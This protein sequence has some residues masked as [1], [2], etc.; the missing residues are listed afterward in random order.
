MDVNTA[1]SIQHQLN[2]GDQANKK[3]K[4]T[5]FIVVPPTSSFVKLEDGLLKGIGNH[6]TSSAIN[7]TGVNT[8]SANLITA[9]AVKLTNS[10]G[11]VSSQNLSM[12]NLNSLPVFSTT[13]SQSNNTSTVSTFSNGQIAI[14]TSKPGDKSGLPQTNYLMLNGLTAGNM[15][16]GQFI[17]NSANGQGRS[18][19]MN[20]ICINKLSSAQNGTALTANLGP[21]NS[22]TNGQ[23]SSSVSLAGAISQ[24]A[25]DAINGAANNKVSVQY[26]SVSYNNSGN[27]SITNANPSS[28]AS[29]AA[30][31]G[32]GTF[33]INSAD[34]Q[35]QILNSLKS[36]DLNLGLLKSFVPATTI[37]TNS[38]QQTSGNSNNT[39]S[40]QQKTSFSVPSTNSNFAN[41]PTNNCDQ[42]STNNQPLN[43]DDCQ[44]TLHGSTAGQMSITN[45]SLTNSLA[46][47]LLNS[48]AN[49]LNQT[50]DADEKH[51]R[52]ESHSP[53]NEGALTDFDIKTLNSHNLLNATN[54]LLISP[55]DFLTLTEDHN[56]NV[57]SNQT[58]SSNYMRNSAV[59]RDVSLSSG[60][61]SSN[62]ELLRKSSGYLG[63]LNNSFIGFERFCESPLFI[64][65]HRDMLDDDEDDDELKDVNKEFINSED[66]FFGT[67][68][69]DGQN[70]DQSQLDQLVFILDHQ[71]TEPPESNNHTASNTGSC[72]TADQPSGGNNCVVILDINQQQQQQQQSSNQNSSNNGKITIKTE[73]N[74]SFPSNGSSTSSSQ[75]AN[76]NSVLLNC[77]T[78]N[79]NLLNKSSHQ[80]LSDS[81]L[82]LTNS[83]SADLNGSLLASQAVNSKLIDGIKYIIHQND[84]GKLDGKHKDGLIKINNL[85]AYLTNTTGLENGQQLIVNMNSADKSK[86]LGSDSL[87]TQAVLI[88]HTGGRANNSSLHRQSLL[89]SGQLNN[90]K[91]NGNSNGVHVKGNAIKNEVQ[92]SE[93]IVQTDLSSIKTEKPDHLPTLSAGDLDLTNLFG[94]NTTNISV[95]VSVANAEDS[96]VSSTTS[97][98]S[99]K[100]A[101]I[102]CSPDSSSALLCGTTGKLNATNSFL[103]FQNSTNSANNLV[104]NSMAILTNGNPNSTNNSSNSTTTSHLTSCTPALVATPNSA[105]N[106]STYTLLPTGLLQLAA[107][108]AAVFPSS[109]V[110]KQVALQ[111]LR[112]DGSS[113]I[114]PIVPNRNAAAGG[115]QNSAGNLSGNSSA[116]NQDGTNSSMHQTSSMPQ[117]TQLITISADSL[118]NLIQGGLN[119]NVIATITTGQTA[120]NPTVISTSLGGQ[121][122]A[123]TTSSTTS[124]ANDQD[125]PFKCDLCNATFTRLGNFT[126][127]KKIHSLPSKDQ[128]FKC[129]T[130]QKSFIQRCDLA[131]H[132]HI[133]RGTEPHRCKFFRNRGLSKKRILI[134]Q[135]VSFS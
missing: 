21:A 103:S 76:S 55:T 129:E 111:L 50:A 85:P 46:N 43:L 83:D 91:M 1:P 65:H 32:N 27:I 61:L 131:R 45:N 47:C 10:N 57:S 113:L 42:Q 130:C 119:G 60:C 101:K 78:S 92:L 9:A 75:T 37:S 97:G 87:G 12:A 100:N 63:S 23:V 122:S 135:I 8:S 104:N 108:I 20:S 89:T 56:N 54:R 128:R 134:N 96:A 88:Q 39:G 73:P 6:L 18:H 81:L 114:V 95:N 11:N 116:I 106:G 16:S 84:A 66:L 127:H 102:V 71:Q 99:S 107:N 62:V 33:T 19:P 126:R 124:I 53:L 98:N 82:Q 79:S 13:S 59:K 58:N 30:L 94:K 7:T 105:G 77:L 117:A 72:S 115:Q 70:L 41:G 2:N 64:D 22:S 120:T 80:Q 93:A 48:S 5:P 125:R 74:Q 40:K 38:T 28:A 24:S 4:L 121:S 25:L 29:L 15:L 132:L 31:N 3:I 118:N 14:A 36:S 67:S 86:L 112:E 26:L 123:S 69:S 133:H 49:S 109:N 44:L 90:G 35:Q 110:Q 51:I 68:L 17:E 34:L 52:I